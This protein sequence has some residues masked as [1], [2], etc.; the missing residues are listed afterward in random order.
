MSTES[1]L[2]IKERVTAAQES[3]ASVPIVAL[4]G[5]PPEGTPDG[6]SAWAVGPLWGPR[7]IVIVPTLL[8]DAPQPVVDRL[9]ARVVATATGACPMCSRTAALDPAH[10]RR[11]SVQHD[12]G[13]PAIFENADARWFITTKE[14]TP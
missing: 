6:F 7:S 9:V 2:S 12:N 8:P 5:T 14:Q 13:C 4:L 11:L 3:A 1:F 10:P